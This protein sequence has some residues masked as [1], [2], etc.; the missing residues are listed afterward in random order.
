[1]RK[2]LVSACLLGEPVRFDGRAALAHSEFLSRWSAEGRLVA[3][4]PELAGGL[5]VPREPAEIVGG[6]G[7][8][9]LAGRARVLCRSGRDVTEAYLRGASLALELAR[10]HQVAVA[11][12]KSRSPSCGTHELHAGRFDGALR[13]GMGVTAALLRENGIAVYDELELER[14]AAHV[15][16]LDK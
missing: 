5:A 16:D 2:I 1:M 3:I 14:A 15:A 6:A 4:C 8:D 9:V 13:N 7:A 10:Q 11:I 12:L